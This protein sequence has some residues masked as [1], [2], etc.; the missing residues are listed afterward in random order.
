MAS[1][2]HPSTSQH[3]TPTLVTTSGSHSLL[4]RN[5]VV[6]LQS[7]SELFICLCEDTRYLPATKY[8]TLDTN[9][10]LM[11]AH[12]LRRWP[13]I[14]TTLVQLRCC[15][16]V[17]KAELTQANQWWF[18]KTWHGIEARF[19]FAALTVWQK[20]Q[21]FSAPKTSVP[22]SIVSTYHIELNPAIALLISAN[23]FHYPNHKTLNQTIFPSLRK[24]WV[25]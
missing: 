22:S 20:N 3:T 4:G 21:R 16:E 10:F 19:I 25:A 15:K 5:S 7:V 13:T 6:G 9:T 12:R 1:A 11:L 8:Q 2:V 18:C 23:Y 17:N 24:W 14:N